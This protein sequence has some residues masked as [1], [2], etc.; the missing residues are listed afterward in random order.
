MMVKER[1][2]MHLIL[3]IK[4][5]KPLFVF[6]V[7]LVALLLMPLG[8]LAWAWRRVEDFGQSEM[9]LVLEKELNME[10]SA[11]DIDVRF[12][13]AAGYR[14]LALKIINPIFE[15]DGLPL[16]NKARTLASLAGDRVEA[17][18]DVQTIIVRV[19]H[20][21]GNVLLHNSTTIRNFQ[22]QFAE[23]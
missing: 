9:E 16:A 3:S 1:K 6:L 11:R 5:T 23:I 13:K 15:N 22:F 10:L 2:G 18:N 4:G 8:D 19:I 21:K 20:L 17:D 14:T 7:L 12:G